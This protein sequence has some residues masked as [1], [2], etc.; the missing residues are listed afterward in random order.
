MTSKTKSRNVDCRICVTQEI[1]HIQV[2]SIDYRESSNY[3]K[4]IIVACVRP[5]RS[6]PRS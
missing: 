3:S 6:P 4:L 1:L 5:R 2:K